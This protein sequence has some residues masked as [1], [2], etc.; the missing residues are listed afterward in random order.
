MKYIS[1]KNNI[2]DWILSA[3]EEAKLTAEERKA[4]FE[5]YR[6]FCVERKTTNTTIGAT[7]IAPKLKKP[8]N[9]IAKFLTKALVGKDVEITT[10]GLENISEGPV[11]F[12]NTHQGILD[13]FAWIIDCPRHALILHTTEVKKLLLLAQ[14]NTGLIL[15]TKKK[16]NVKHR[17]NAKL[18]VISALLRG[19]S[20]WI[21]PE[22]AWN[23][24]PN[25]LYLPMYNGFLDM[26]QKAKVDVIPMVMEY[27]YDT[28]R[29]K[30]KI[31]RVHIR[32]G[33]PIKVNEED[34]LVEKLLEYQERIATIRWELIEEK[35]LFKR[36]EISNIDYINFL[37]AELR[38]LEM[39]GINIEDERERLFSSHDEFW[40][41][42]HVNDVPYD[43]WGELLET[44]EVRRLKRINR[45]KLSVY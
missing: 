31:T 35:G 23:L 1:K 26:A 32:Y 13:N 41:F 37:K 42:H 38:N 8:T 6:R 14:L 2:P 25:K 5:K 39:G 29:P 36:S 44:E 20:V 7:T 15:V 34:N 3:K 4:Y 33:E 24:S 45:E 22:T 40:K 11:I 27:T 16:E 28:S 30:E 19:T 10:D 9:K 18:D 12:A 21:C 17:V 43:A